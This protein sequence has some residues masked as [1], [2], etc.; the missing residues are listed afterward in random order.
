MKA[1]WADRPMTLIL[2]KRIPALLLLFLLT[3]QSYAQTASRRAIPATPQQVRKEFLHAWNAYKQYAWGHDS[4]LPLSKKPYDWYGQSL[5]MTP[6]DALDT[7]I[8]M[9][10]DKEAQK[11]REAIAANLSFDKDIYVQNFEVTIRLLGGLLTSYQ[12]TN[13]KR[14]LNLA[15]DLGTRLLPVFNSTTGIPYRFV[16]LRTGKVKEHETNPAEAGTLLIEFGTLSKLTGK[17]IFYE[18][19]KRA[20]VEVYK[21]RSPLGLVGST[22]NVETGEWTSTDSH[23][24]GGID[25]Y[26]EYLLKC[27]LL[28]GDTECRDMWQTSIVAVNKYLSD[29]AGSALWYG[30]ADMRKG[31][32]TATTFGA[33]EAFFPAV[34]ALS[35]DLDRARRSQQACFQMWKLHGIEPEE[36]NYKTMKVTN[37]AYPLRPEIVESAYYLSYLTREPLY[38]EMGRAFFRDFVSYC[39][40][41]TGYAALQ[42]VIDKRKHDRMESFLFAET[43]KY[44]YLLFSPPGAF[45]FKNV[46]FNTEAHPIRKSWKE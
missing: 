21:R 23:I 24:G 32:R 9:G 43:F 28:F 41:D 1:I 31:E 7:L 34:L 3:S 14:L 36:L 38:R 20:L 25:S 6:V 27:W 40:V 8:L 13:D 5:W 29:M 26:Y 22:I 15:E 42:N 35:G 11:T 45:D 10:L 33:L 18:K 17:P 30:H 44:F 37:P 12:M 16:N 4:L 19:A 39:R 2:S 46:V